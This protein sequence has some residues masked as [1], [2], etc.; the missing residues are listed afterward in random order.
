MEWVLPV[1]VARLG[2]EPAVEQSEPVRLELLEMMNSCLETFPHDIAKRGFLDYFATVLCVCLK[3]ADPEMKMLC[4][5]CVLS[6]C[7][8]CRE[9]TKPVAINIAKAMKPNLRVK[10]WK[11]RQAS[12]KA[13]GALV[14][15]GALEIIYDFR[16]EANE[17]QTTLSFMK[18]LSCDRS[19][20]VRSAT[21][22]VISELTMEIVDRIDTHRH[23]MPLILLSMTD[24]LESIR[25]KSQQILL[26]L[27]AF[28][29]MDNE[30]NRIDLE[31]RR[32]TLK[33]IKWYAD[34]TYPDM[35]MVT[36]STLPGT[37]LTSRP[38]IGMFCC[39]FIF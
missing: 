20:A 36:K 10:Q 15:N 33:D 38:P 24:D 7:S 3:D 17:L 25:K 35:T 13:F 9:Q 27:S 19:E 29:E 11:V 5:K 32:I 21:L 23:F 12:I 26:G 39:Y 16:D 18:T 22:D 31:N 1:A 4:S 37:D 2:M 28:Y 14:A 6:L 8:A 30:D 34:D